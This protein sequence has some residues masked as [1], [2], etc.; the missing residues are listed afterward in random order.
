MR[1]EKNGE[2]KYKLTT[3]SFSEVGAAICCVFFPF[4]D[5]V[6]GLPMN[7]GPIDAN[8]AS[9]VAWTC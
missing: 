1:K 3:V 2:A 8:A 9:G 4:A 7:R 5:V 6:K